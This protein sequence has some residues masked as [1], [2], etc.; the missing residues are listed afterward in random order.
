MKMLLT[1]LESQEN[2]ALK[3]RRNKKNIHGIQFYKNYTCNDS[4]IKALS[5]MLRTI[6][7]PI[8]E[9]ALRLLLANIALQLF[10]PITATEKAPILSFLEGKLKLAIYQPLI[11]DLLGNCRNV[12]DHIPSA[13]LS[14]R[15][16][17]SIGQDLLG[18]AY[19]S[20][21]DTGERKTS[22][23]YYTPIFIVQQ[24]VQ[25]LKA[26]ISLEGVSFY[27]PCCGTGNFFLGLQQEG[28]LLTQLHGQDIDPIS[29][30]LARINLAL[31]YRPKDL[32]PLYENFLQGDSLIAPPKRRF[33]VILGNPPWGNTLSCEQ[34][35]KLR[36]YRTASKKS[37]EAS[38]VFIE[39]ASHLLSEN[40]ILM[41]IV[42]QSLLQV[43]AHQPLRRLLLTD[44][45]I[46]F[47]SY[48]GEV[49]SGVQ[50]PSLLLGVQKSSSPGISGC[51][52][53]TLTRS[54]LIQKERRLSD[55]GFSLDITDEEQ[56]CID[57]MEQIPN[58]CTL[59]GNATFALGIVTGNNR[60]LLSAAPFPQAEPVWKGSDLMRYHIAPNPQLYLRFTPEIFQQ[61]APIDAYRAK[62]KLFYRFICDSLVFSYDN[63]QRLSLNSCNILIPQITDLEIKY[64]L[65]VL[66]SRAANFYWKK[67]FHSVKVLR[68]HLEQIPIPIAEPWLQK[69]LIEKTDC[70]LNR[71]GSINSLYDTM[72]EMVM[73]AYGFDSDMQT[74]ICKALERCPLFLD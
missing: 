1:H 56:A 50:C 71:E 16:H 33:D 55:E 39:H 32:S 23:S 38:S 40:G 22:G 20:L 14:C 58:R 13:L 24:A 53:T 73:N 10:S 25:H 29:I 37:I 65:A 18:M 62:E 45:H 12:P 68:S 44:F 15:F 21:R 48:L 2:P 43:S 49:F 5:A 27:D 6:Q 61:V 7:Q 31:A 41:F 63:C 34:I 46:R 54:F 30:Q 35:E 47:A 66:N 3:R 4:N 52:V 67:R 72:D 74:C 26:Q 9:S 42:P 51:R 60:S 19:L 28:V 70:L 17:Y 69:K 59:A 57:F 36:H 64:I 11:E 8:T